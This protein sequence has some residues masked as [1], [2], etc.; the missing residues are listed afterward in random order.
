MGEDDGGD[1]RGELL[2]V[3]GGGG[4]DGGGKRGGEAAEFEGAASEVE[5]HGK[6]DDRRPKLQILRTNAWFPSLFEYDSIFIK[7]QK[8]FLIFYY[9]GKLLGMIDY[10]IYIFVFCHTCIVIETNEYFRSRKQNVL[11]IFKK[12]TLHLII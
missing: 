6:N 2:G 7:N 4:G 12:F 10:I 8:P 3:S 5:K 1:D 11:I 9:Y